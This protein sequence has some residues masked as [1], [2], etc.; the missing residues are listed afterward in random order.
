MGEGVVTEVVRHIHP[1][2]KAEILN[3]V[4]EAAGE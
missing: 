2:R 4:E 3:E 1:K